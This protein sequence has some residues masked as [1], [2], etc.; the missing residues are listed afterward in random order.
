MVKNFY[1]YG[2]YKYE[3]KI[4]AA[5]DD[6]KDKYRGMYASLKPKMAEASTTVEKSSE[7]EK[8]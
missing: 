1:D 7:E 8:K 4:C 6:A 5:M 3:D 2:T